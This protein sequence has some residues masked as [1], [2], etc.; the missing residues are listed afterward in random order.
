MTIVKQLLLSITSHSELSK[1]ELF[2]S[3][4]HKVVQAVTSRNKQ[5][6]IIKK[7]ILVCQGTNIIWLQ[8]YCRALAKASKKKLL[9]PS[10][11]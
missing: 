5:Y 11:I 10:S 2:E 4:Q 6:N 1:K 8:E 7:S 9:S 3:T